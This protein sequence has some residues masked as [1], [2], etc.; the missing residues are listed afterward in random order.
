M[1]MRMVAIVAVGAGL[2]ALG[3][4]GKGFR[5]YCDKCMDTYSEDGCKAAAKSE[6]KYAKALKCGK[7]FRDLD[8]CLKDVSACEDASSCQGEWDDYEKCNCKASVEDTSVCQ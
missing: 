5:D 3:C 8:K 7:E 6:A 2:L 1:R 4:T